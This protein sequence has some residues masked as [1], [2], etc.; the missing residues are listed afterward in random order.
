MTTSLIVALTV[1]AILA[2]VTRLTLLAPSR[3]ID[4]SEDERRAAIIRA[5]EVCRMILTDEGI[6]IPDLT[7]QERDLLRTP[8]AEW[9]ERAAR[10]VATQAH[11]AYAAA[12]PRS[13]INRDSQWPS[14]RA[15]LVDEGHE[16]WLLWVERDT[17]GED[18]SNTKETP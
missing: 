16:Q 12:H 18:D 8:P 4:D 15:R 11:R 14:V 6:F 2:I 1:L 13:E 9:A 7:E 10:D 5:A 17:T 3:I